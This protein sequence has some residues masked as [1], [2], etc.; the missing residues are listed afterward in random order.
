MKTLEKFYIRGN[1]LTK[2]IDSEK[3]TLQSMRV[4]YEETKMGPPLIFQDQIIFDLYL[5]ILLINTHFVPTRRPAIGMCTGDYVDDK[6]K[7][8][9]YG[10]EDVALTNAISL[11]LARQYESLMNQWFVVKDKV[12]RNLKIVTDFVEKDEPV[13]FKEWDLGIENFIDHTGFTSTDTPCKK[14]LDSL[15]NAWVNCQPNLFKDSSAVLGIKFS[16]WRRLVNETIYPKV[17]EI[18]M[19]TI[20]DNV[21]GIQTDISDPNGTFF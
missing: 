4:V 1:E 20:H 2:K 18:L 13:F 11:H 7:K 15:K 14:Y 5:F 17:S 12:Y 9:I 16:N 21:L 6:D 19:E 3:T 8:Y 10:Y